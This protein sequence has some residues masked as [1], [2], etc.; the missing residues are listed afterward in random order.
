LPSVS[1]DVAER[2]TGVYHPRNPKASPLYGLVEDYFD[3]FERVYEERFAE[4]YVFWWPVIRK[5]ADRFPDCGDLR[6]G[7][8]T[9]AHSR[10]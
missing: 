8:V 10:Q 3:E 6:Y 1:G 7:L 5:V 4:K 2:I 9:K